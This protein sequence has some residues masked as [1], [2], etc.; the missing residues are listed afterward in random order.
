MKLVVVGDGG[1]GKTSLL[2][3]YTV[4]HCFQ[5]KKYLPTLFDNYSAF[6]KVADKTV[7]LSLW[8]T[9]AQEDH[10]RLRPLSYCATDIFLL[11]FSVVSEQ[12]FKNIKTKWWPEVTYYCP[13]KNIVVGTKVDLREDPTFLERLAEGGRA[14]V[15]TEQ[16]QQLAADIKAIK[17]LE[18]S[19]L[20]Q[21]NLNEIF[22]F[23]VSCALDRKQAHKKKSCTMF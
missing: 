18:C 4:Q 17:Y 23:A 22:D 15:S 14:P 6:V 20:T 19:S 1:V 21:Q 13:T 5:S 12:S 11:C 7:A 2:V 3:C 9:T 8:D 16:G 10:D